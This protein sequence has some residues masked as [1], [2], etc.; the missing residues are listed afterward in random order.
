ME[1]SRTGTPRSCLSNVTNSV[2]GSG[3]CLLSLSELQVT[4]L[5]MGTK[6]LVL[7]VSPWENKTRG[8]T[9]KCVRKHDCYTMSCDWTPSISGIEHF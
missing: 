7:T 6:S 3:L 8:W 4:L 5:S 9:W 2:F 1:G